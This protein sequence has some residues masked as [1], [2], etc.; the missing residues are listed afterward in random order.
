MEPVMITKN[1]IAN[2][3]FTILKRLEGGEKPNQGAIDAIAIKGYLSVLEYLYSNK[4]RVSTSTANYIAFNG[5]IETLKF[6]LD[7]G[8]T[9][10]VRTNHFASDKVKELIKNSVTKSSRQKYLETHKCACA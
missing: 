8:H 2:D 5:D 1:Y 4:Y 3:S 6:L 9:F 7:H 10:T